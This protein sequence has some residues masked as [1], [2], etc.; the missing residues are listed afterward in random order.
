MKKAS[1]AA[2]RPI[3]TPEDKG[4]IIFLDYRFATAYCLRFLPLW[5]RQNLKTLADKDQLI[6]Q[7]LRYFFKQGF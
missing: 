2:G 5:I 4:A 1:Q 7:E 6:Q 3:R